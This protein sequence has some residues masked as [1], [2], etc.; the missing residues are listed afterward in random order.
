L[1]VQI[2]EV[3]SPEEAAVL[4]GIGVDHTGVLVGSGAFPRE[5]SIAR[6]RE[7]FSTISAPSQA[8]AL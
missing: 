2:Y 5:R 4:C 7:I 6:A 8:S 3:S 1:I